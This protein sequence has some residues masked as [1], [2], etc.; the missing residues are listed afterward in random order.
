VIELIDVTKRYAR[1][2]EAL[3]GINLSIESGAMA[4]LTGHSGAG[5]TTVLRLLAGLELCSEGQVRV[6]GQDLSRLRP[7]TM[8]HYRRRVGLVFQD[9]RLLADRSV[10]DNVALPLII[11]GTP[12]RDIE[13]RVHAA[14]ERIGLRQRRDAM[15]VVLSSGEQQRVGIARAVVARPPILLA[16]E[17]T[18]NLDPA[19]SHEMMSL[20]EDFNRVGT[21]IVIATHDL[22]L[23]DA[24]PYRRITL[25]E[26][27]CAE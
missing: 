7:E 27:R 18:G 25:R 17:P 20:F 12:P 10:F 26:G 21:T 3:S 14:L 4:F 24:F 16:D 9:H 2:G 15:P 11:S 6:G 1:S 8:P 13:R 5:K 23:I 19:L 22:A